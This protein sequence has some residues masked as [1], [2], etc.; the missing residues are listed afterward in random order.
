MRRF[1]ECSQPGVIVRRLYL[2]WPLA[3]TA[4]FHATAFAA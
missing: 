3:R 4:F 1:E 2:C